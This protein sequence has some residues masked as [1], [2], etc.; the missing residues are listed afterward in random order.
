MPSYII[1][2]DV[3]PGQAI[4]PTA[5][6]VFFPPKDSDELFDALRM[7]YP[8]LRTHSERMGQA[9]IEF[10]M[11]E[12]QLPQMPVEQL[13]TPTTANSVMTSPWE[14]SMQSMSSGSSTWSSPELLDLA[15]PTF[16]N[17]PQP[18]TVA[19]SRQESTATTTTMASNQTPPAIEQMTGVFSLSDAAQPKQRVRRKMTETEKV[20][21]RKRRIVKACEKCSKRKR[22]CNHNQPDMEGVATSKAQKVTKPS[23]IGVSKKPPLGTPQVQAEQPM[24]GASTIEFN[25]SFGSEMSIPELDEFAT[26]FEDPLP[27]MS[28]D[29]LFMP[30]D[31]PWAWSNTADFTL[32]DSSSGALY[33]MNQAPQ[34]VPTEPGHGSGSASWFDQSVGH[35]VE[36]FDHDVMQI[37]GGGTDKKMLWEHLRTG[38]EDIV[39]EKQQP[40]HTRHMHEMER[41]EEHECVQRGDEIDA[42]EAYEYDADYMAPRFDWNQPGRA[43]KGWPQHHIQKEAMKSDTDDIAYADWDRRGVQSDLR[44]PSDRMQDGSQHPSTSLSQMTLRLTGTAKAVKAFG[45]LLPPSS[46]Q[47]QRLQS[48]SLKKVALLA[49]GG[50]SVAQGLQQQQV[51]D[52]RPRS[53]NDLSCAIG[54]TKISSSNAMDLSR[55]LNR[56]HPQRVPR[57][58]PRIDAQSSDIHDRR[59]PLPD[60]GRLEGMTIE[61]YLRMHT[62]AT[63]V[64]EDGRATQS[65]A[66][67]TPKTP[68]SR[69]ATSIALASD[70]SPANVERSVKSKI[71]GT[72]PDSVLN[73]ATTQRL[74]SA[75]AQQGRPITSLGEGITTSTSPSMELFFL[76][77]RGTR[78]LGFDRSGPAAALGPLLM[79]IPPDVDTYHAGDHEREIIISRNTECMEGNQHS[80]LSD[81]GAYLTADPAHYNK[82]ILSVHTGGSGAASSSAQPVHTRPNRPS[83]SGFFGE[84]SSVAAAP[85]SSNA[86]LAVNTVRVP[87]STANAVAAERLSDH[88]RNRDHFGRP[89]RSNLVA[90][91]MFSLAAFATL[92]LLSFVQTTSATLSILLLALAAPVQGSKGNVESISSARLRPLRDWLENSSWHTGSL[93]KH[94]RFRLE[95]CRARGVV[96]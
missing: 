36:W 53:C 25:G 59:A 28:L 71:Q 94:L 81:G 20:E 68:R 65:T 83:T 60:T 63:P 43:N 87:S 90:G 30:T 91:L 35:D 5:P 26:M 31:Q 10:L 52:L 19:L 89:S 76:K 23:L 79:T 82:P 69:D 88:F 40:T 1:C 8:T 24:F 38:Q 51:A 78:G 33:D 2:R 3:Q 41:P 75:A 56:S 85:L 96:V 14:T 32:M 15:T 42:K 86:T 9:V 37:T 61:D 47:K 12:Q 34:V 84:T 17:S 7:K 16:G 67:T 64:Q 55:H 80:H 70:G 92:V 77:R 50:F 57:G 95:W 74:R 22:K 46:T 29:D 48:V 6:L 39:T 49:L 4:D 44:R 93:P 13:A 27:D 45:S 21:Y 66:S 54:G 58:D 11:E 73:S 62:N 18:Q 72:N